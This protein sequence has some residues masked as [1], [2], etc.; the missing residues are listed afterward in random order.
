MGLR[1]KMDE[2]PTATMCVALLA[3]ALSVGLALWYVMV[4]AATR[5]EVGQAWYF[6]LSTSQLFQA[7]PQPAPINAPSGPYKGGP[8]G[9]K[10]YLFACHDCA[11]PKDRFVGYLERFL[12]AG[13]A[14][15]E[16]GIRSGRMPDMVIF[17]L[18]EQDPM[19][20]GIA[21]VKTPTGDDWADL[22]SPE[23]AKIVSGFKSK[24]EGE[25]EAVPCP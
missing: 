12:P 7:K 24:C 25:E 5:A 23:A 15:A 21:E 4:P 22:S 20:A 1:Q 14:T 18:L 2:H 6:D 11:D 8:G 16:A 17:G 10:A 19:P 13:K 9:V 3:A